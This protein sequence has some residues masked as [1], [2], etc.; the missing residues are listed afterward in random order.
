MAQ[1]DAREM[2][3]V[4]QNRVGDLQ[5]HMDQRISNIEKIFVTTMAPLVE[6][7]D[8]LVRQQVLTVTSVLAADI[9]Y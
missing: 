8:I 9:L 7:L 4:L 1:L 6:T 2:Y 5:H 3:Q